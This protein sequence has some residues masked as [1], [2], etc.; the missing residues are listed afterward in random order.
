MKHD[1]SLQ[2]KLL[3][4]SNISNCVF[5]FLLIC[6]VQKKATSLALGSFLLQPFEEIDVTF[7]VLFLLY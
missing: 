4:F 5:L 7:V 6:S 3:I 1:F 2:K